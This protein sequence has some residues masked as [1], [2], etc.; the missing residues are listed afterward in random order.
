MTDNRLISTADQKV[1]IDF[2]RNAMRLNT[3]IPAIID[4][5]DP[6]TQ[7]VSATPAIKAKYITPDNNVIYIQYPK[8][9]NIPL[10]M[11]KSQGLKIT[12]PIEVGQNCTLIFSQRSIDN[13]MLEGNIQ[14]P[15]DGENPITSTIRCMDLTD[16]MCFPGIIT[17]KE[18][19]TEYATDAIEVRSADGK[20]KLSVKEN[21]LKLAQESAS[22][23]L[24]GGN[25]TMN[26]AQI[27]ING[28]QI[29]L[30]GTAAV[31]VASPATVIDSKN[32]L[33]HTHGGVTSGQGT[34]GGVS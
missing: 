1:E 33:T 6:S 10:A 23:E 14:A 12:Y 15:F 18:P 24:S 32:F 2:W 19:I 22:I 25:I 8:I 28:T 13:F 7:R 30:T 34:T 4:G 31:N 21:S 29:D 17:D 5:F 20:V 26:A 3:A 11:I 16:A 27:T 9:T